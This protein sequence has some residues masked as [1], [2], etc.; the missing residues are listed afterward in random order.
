MSFT[1]RSLG[2]RFFLSLVACALA[3][4][5]LGRELPG[6]LVDVRTPPIAVRCDF[7]RAPN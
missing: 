2:P 1:L 6:I 5:D 3:A 4:Q 7:G